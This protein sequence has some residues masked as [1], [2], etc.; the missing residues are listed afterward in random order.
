[1]SLLGEV[2]LH[3]SD[4]WTSAAQPLIGMRSFAR[5]AAENSRREGGDPRCCKLTRWQDCGMV[6]DVAGQSYAWHCSVHRASCSV[7]VSPSWDF[8]VCV[9]RVA[10][11]AR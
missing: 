1:M 10:C 6:E 4:N 7:R 2:P 3:R 9:A 11:W 5:A 8:A